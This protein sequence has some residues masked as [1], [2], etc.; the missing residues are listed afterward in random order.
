VGSHTTYA[1][2]CTRAHAHTHTHT[3]EDPS[4]SHSNNCVGVGVGERG[5]NVVTWEMEYICLTA[6]GMYLCYHQMG[7][8]V[9]ECIHISHENIMLV[10]IKWNRTHTREKH[11]AM[12]EMHRSAM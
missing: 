6:C 10:T 8:Y 1:C 11:F 3:G 5:K 2:A 4:V 7:V 9:Q 12:A